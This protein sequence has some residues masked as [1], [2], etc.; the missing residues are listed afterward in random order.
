[1]QHNLVFTLTAD[2]TVL[3]IDERSLW[4]NPAFP[5]TEFPLMTLPNPTLASDFG[6]HPNSYGTKHAL[7]VIT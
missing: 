1:M 3:L 6:R 2:V 5:Y 7:F 4:G